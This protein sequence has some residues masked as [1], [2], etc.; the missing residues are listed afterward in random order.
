MQAPRPYASLFSGFISLVAVVVFGYVLL[1]GLA[2]TPFSS[3][4]AV[5]DWQTEAIQF[6]ADDVNTAVYNITIGPPGADLYALEDSRD[7]I[8]GTITFQDEYLFDH[9][10][11]GSKATIRL[12][13]QNRSE[14]WVF[15]PDYWREYGETNRWQ[16]GL[17][18]T[19]PAELTVEAVAGRSELD[20][21]DMLLESL[22][23]SVNAGDMALLLPGGNYDANLITNAGVNE[24]TL[25]EDGRHAINLEV[26]AGSVTLHLLPDLPS[27]MGTLSTPLSEVD[28]AAGQAFNAND[29]GSPRPGVG[30]SLLLVIWWRRGG[31]APTLQVDGQENVWETADYANTDNQ[32]DLN[33]HTAVFTSVIDVA[34]LGPP[35]LPRCLLTIP[36]AFLVDVLATSLSAPN[37]GRLGKR[38]INP[39]M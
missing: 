32:I 25:P 23:L 1:N 11:S 3:R 8:A 26:N 38:L 19:I 36:A 7:L 35:A 33:L 31:V 15:L 16:L 27:G 10:V 13:P 21:R 24:I 4:L 5:G 30:A 28:R 37:F 9:R 2:G 34:P 18:G 12:A 17:N 29:A 6:G 14:E 20:L 22:M 39:I